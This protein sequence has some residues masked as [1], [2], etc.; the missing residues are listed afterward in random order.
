[1]QIKGRSVDERDEGRGKMLGS[2]IVQIILF[3]YIILHCYIMFTCEYIT[4]NPIIMYNYKAPIKMCKEKSR[5][6]GCGSEGCCLS[7]L[8]VE[9][10]DLLLNV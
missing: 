4:T 2:E 5:D 1:M 8:R 9:V 7:K 6:F 10:L 3:C